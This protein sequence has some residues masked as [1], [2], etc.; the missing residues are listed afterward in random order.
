MRYEIVCYAV[1]QAFHECH[2]GHVLWHVATLKSNTVIRP[3]DVG[4][5]DRLIC[6]IRSPGAT[7]QRIPSDVAPSFAT[8]VLHGGLVPRGL[9][10]GGIAAQ[11]G[12]ADSAN[13]SFQAPL[14]CYFLLTLLILLTLLFLTLL[15]LTLLTLL[16]L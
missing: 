12:P 1:L 6:I 9:P 7:W 3:N 5:Y 15:H 11:T 4:I 14:L 13:R 10:S 2:R 8:I 16:V